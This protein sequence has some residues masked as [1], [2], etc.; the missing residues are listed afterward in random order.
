M[1]KLTGSLAHVSQ[2]N[3]FPFSTSCRCLGDTR[4][5]RTTAQALRGALSVEYLPPV[6]SVE[7]G[8]TEQDEEELTPAT[9]DS[10]GV[11]GRDI[12]VLEQS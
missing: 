2:G 1:G 4:E 12:T 3:P 11:G 7:E 8:P 5:L 9:S 6:T 10:E